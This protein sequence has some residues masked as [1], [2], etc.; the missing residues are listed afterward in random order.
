MAFFKKKANKVKDNDLRLFASLL[1][2]GL[3]LAYRLSRDKIEAEVFT[4]ISGARRSP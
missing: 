1:Y 4:L 3:Y 2:S